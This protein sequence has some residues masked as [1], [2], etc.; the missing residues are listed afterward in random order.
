MHAAVDSGSV[1]MM[2]HVLELGVDVDERDNWTNM[3]YYWYGTPLLRA[4]EKGKTDAVRFLLE[5][6]A[7]TTARGHVGMT[8]ERHVGW[9][10]LEMVKRDWVIDEIRKMVEEVGEREGKGTEEDP[11]SGGGSEEGIESSLSK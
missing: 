4:I 2:A 9:T 1:D 10:A 6:G 7:S 11:R 5:K 8:A 3:G